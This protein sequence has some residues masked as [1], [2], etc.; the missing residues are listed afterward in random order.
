MPFIQHLFPEAKI[1][2][3]IVSPGEGNI[4]FGAEL[5]ELILEK[6]NKKIKYLNE[7][8]EKLK[9]EKYNIEDKFKKLIEFS[10]DQFEKLAAEPVKEPVVKD[11]NPLRKEKRKSVFF[12]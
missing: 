12:K 11:K 5:G 7:E 10:K 4:G 2:P 6:A 3:V 8:V 9:E 1:V